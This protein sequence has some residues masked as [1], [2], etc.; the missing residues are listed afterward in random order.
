MQERGGLTKNDL[1]K[2]GYITISIT[3]AFK[4]WNI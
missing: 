3:D 2:A 1:Q 4:A